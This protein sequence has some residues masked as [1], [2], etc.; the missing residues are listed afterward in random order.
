MITSNL[1]RG[2]WLLTQLLVILF[3]LLVVRN[4]Y[5]QQP[6]RIYVY[7]GFTA[8]VNSNVQIFPSLT[9]HQTEPEISVHPSNPSH[10]VASANI[11][12]N[13]PP[14]GR[15]ISTS[16]GSSWYG[17][18]A[19]PTA[20]ALGDP[21]TAVDLNGHMYV[22]YLVDGGGI[23]LSK[24]T[25]L[26]QTWE[27]RVTGA[28]GADMPHLTIDNSGGQHSGNLYITYR[29]TEGS[30]NPIYFM[31]STDG[32][33]SW[34]SIQ[35]IS[36]SSG[37]TN[38]NGARI[39]VGV[40]GELFAVWNYDAETLGS[41]RIGFNVSSDGGATWGTPRTIFSI[42][43][44]PPVLKSGTSRWAVNSLP[45]LAYDR[46]SGPHRGWLYVAWNQKDN[47]PAGSDPDILLSRST[48]SGITCPRHRWCCLRR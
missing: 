16:A 15:F 38:A 2:R 33:D 46:S 32:G 20:D 47:P 27:H 22:S 13:E 29:G 44:I 4:T 1:F 14:A 24:T 39:Q 30:I 37:F 43:A 18:D 6:S 35:N 28:T 12:E 31:R 36:G 42:Q 8:T 25:N 19:E 34:I 17:T 11:G 7:D 21:G 40:N 3:S 26:G 23:G 10:L 41:Q 48:D 45:S 5:G 9:V